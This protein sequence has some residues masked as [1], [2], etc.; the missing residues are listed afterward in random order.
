MKK[1]FDFTRYRRQRNASG[2]IEIDIDVLR[3]DLDAYEAA[4][5]RDCVERAA[6]IKVAAA[7]LADLARH[8]EPDLDVRL[9]RVWQLEK[10]LG[11]LADLGKLA[12]T[13]SQDSP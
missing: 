10:R 5:R 9:A 11:E 2:L 12:D 4:L 8:P 3:A 13:G 1:P 6:A 7:E